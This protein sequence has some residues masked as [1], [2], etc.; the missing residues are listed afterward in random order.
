LQQRQHQSLQDCV[1]KNEAKV[2]V[3]ESHKRISQSRQKINHLKQ[4]SSKVVQVGIGCEETIQLND[5]GVA[6]KNRKIEQ[7]RRIQV[8]K[9]HRESEHKKNLAI[10]RALKEQNKELSKKRYTYDFNGNLLF[11]K[12]INND[13]IPKSTINLPYTWHKS[14]QEKKEIEDKNIKKRE[15]LSLRGFRQNNPKSPKLFKIPDKFSKT[16]IKSKFEYNEIA[17]FESMK[18]MCGVTMMQKN[19]MKR[20]SL[21]FAESLGKYTRS[22]YQDKISQMRTINTPNGV[23]H[24]GGGDLNFINRVMTPKDGFI[25][26]EN[27]DDFSSQK[28]ML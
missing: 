24:T 3:E 17:S 5:K 12:R 10:K 19:Q 26:I 28:D 9:E 23:I 27:L 11:M 7:Q 1:N 22:D 16:I 13:A 20:S 4:G 15:S 18:P 25:N 2:K 14:E 21:G 8:E 6:L